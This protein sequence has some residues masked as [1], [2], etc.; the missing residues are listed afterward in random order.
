M[1]IPDSYPS[2]PSYLIILQHALY[3]PW[4]S[5]LLNGQLKTWAPPTNPLILH[6]Y[7]TPVNRIFQ[8][9]DQKYWTM[10]WNK[11]LG[12]IVLAFEIVILQ[13]LNRRR[14]STRKTMSNYGF[15]ALEVG[16]LDLNIQMNRKSLALMEYAS[17]IN[18]DFVIF[19]TT[20]SYLNLNTLENFLAT[21]PR[22]NL[23]AGR[24]VEQ[25]GEI[26]PSG[27]FRI[28]S[29]DLLI[30]TLNN[31]NSYKYWLPEDLA[32]GK[33]LNQEPPIFVEVPSVDID[34]YKGIEDLTKTDLELLVH[35]RLKSGTLN[36][37][38]DSALMGRLHNKINARSDQ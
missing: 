31:L 3:E 14:A 1:A 28:F 9:L 20:S 34:S 6:S 29:P 7:A 25:Q 32:L 35:Y 27:S 2:K 4:L 19:T 11:R 38:N 8:W 17:R 30:S 18:V 12:R 10:K 37:R 13:P 22:K 24:M 15:P 16:M 23:A 36:Q 26:F 5:I 21:L 33:L